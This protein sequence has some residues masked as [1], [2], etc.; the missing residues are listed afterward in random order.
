MD[1]IDHNK[2]DGD[3]G[4]RRDARL[5]FFQPCGCFVD[6]LERGPNETRTPYV[7]PWAR[8]GRYLF[9]HDDLIICAETNQQFL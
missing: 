4:R 3:D 7:V 2:R 1:L 9:S 5:K 8:V 6:Q